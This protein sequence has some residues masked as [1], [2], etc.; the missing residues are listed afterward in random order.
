[1]SSVSIDHVYNQRFARL[2]VWPVARQQPSV[3][4]HVITADE[5]EDEMSK[6]SPVVDFFK[7]LLSDEVTRSFSEY[8]PPKGKTSRPMLLLI[9]DLENARGRCDDARI[10]AMIKSARA[11][12]YHDLLGEL[13]E[14]D[15]DIDE[16]L[17]PTMRL[18]FELREN[19]LDDLSDNVR[20]GKYDAKKGDLELKEKDYDDLETRIR[21]IVNARKCAAPPQPLPAPTTTTTG[22]EE[23]DISDDS[24]DFYRPDQPTPERQ[25]IINN[26]Q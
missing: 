25:I 6:P 13:E 1:M 24:D 10:D 18:Y 22:I 14:Y 12:Y 8:K 9:A 4:C 20:N 2:K 3:P 11:E 21:T 5:I 7:Y 19:G 23:N 17:D 16:G 26:Y 15:S